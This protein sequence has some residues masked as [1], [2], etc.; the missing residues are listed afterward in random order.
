VLKNLPVKSE[1]GAESFC[2]SVFDYKQFFLVE[3]LPKQRNIYK[4]SYGFKEFVDLRPTNSLL[5]PDR[6]CVLF[7]RWFCCVCQ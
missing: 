7:S 4:Y 1:E 3:F 5:D 2:L 6:D